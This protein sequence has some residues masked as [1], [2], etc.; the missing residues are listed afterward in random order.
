MWRK[1]NLNF[2]NVVFETFLHLSESSV[3]YLYKVK[4]NKFSVKLILKIKF[5][6]LFLLK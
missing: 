3:F 4:K 1:S 5:I 2:V 6:V